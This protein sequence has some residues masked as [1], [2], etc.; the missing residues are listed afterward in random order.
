MEDFYTTCVQ[1]LG[2]NIE[3]VPTPYR[4]NVRVRLYGPPEEVPQ[5]PIEETIDPAVETE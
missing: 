5:E 3:E 4:E 2:L 1:L